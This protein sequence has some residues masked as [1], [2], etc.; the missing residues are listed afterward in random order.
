MAVATKGALTA[1][2]IVA[3][4][5]SLEQAAA[6]LV[7]S[8]AADDI[9]I[10]E[11]LDA[12]AGGEVLLLEGNYITSQNLT[13]PDDT[14]LR[15]CGFGT[16]ITPTGAAIGGAS[17]GAVEL[18]NRSTLR[19][20]K[21]ILAAGAGG[22][23]TRPNVVMA[24]T[25]TLV[26]IENCWIV[27]DTSV[28]DDGTFIRQ[29]GIYLTSATNSKVID[30]RVEDNDKSSI[31]L[32]NNSDN[33]TITGNTCQGSS[34]YGINLN[35]SSNNIIG[36]NIYYG[37]ARAIYLTSS[38]N[39]TVVSN[40]CQGHSRATIN[41]SISHN[42]TITGNT[43]QG[44]G[45]EGI[46]I[47]A[48]NN[49]TVTGNTFSGNGWHGVSVSNSTN[50]TITGNTCADNGYNGIY[51]DT[52]SQNVITGNQCDDNGSAGTYHG[53][54]IYRS[55]YCTIVGNVC[56]NNLVDGINVTGDATTNSD[57]NTLTGNTCTGNGDDGIE[58]VG[59]GDANKNIVITN[60]LMNNTG[61]ALVDN[62][63]GTE[64]AHNITV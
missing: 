17:N 39:N 32:Y 59:G 42:N 56:A 46:W 6:N 44:N 20:M 64:V 54:Y 37:N 8:G 21:I 55:S 23:G 13:V 10:Q 30:C 43:C 24:D 38:N 19:D 47:S 26:W 58:I 35:T 9:E 7:C 49:N 1:T 34:Y 3:A 22:A 45:R 14:T 60:T 31:N 63:V 62:G 25:K 61:A 50:N 16:V 57:Y 15:G 40:T 12:A 33:N 41:L 28:A 5:N 53:I 36:G 18:G 52:S 2:L 11:A 29:N 51:I 4:S 48:S 27:G